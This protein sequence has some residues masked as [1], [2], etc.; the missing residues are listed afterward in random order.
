MWVIGA[1]TH[2]GEKVNK[3]GYYSAIVA[4]RKAG[5]KGEPVKAK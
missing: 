2:E 1:F 3:R 4:A 5:V